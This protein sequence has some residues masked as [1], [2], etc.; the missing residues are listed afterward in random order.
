MGTRWVMPQNL[1]TAAE[2]LFSNDP[3]R[4]VTR[5]LPAAY[6]GSGKLPKA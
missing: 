5:P 2:V 1:G 3:A 6:Q 4:G